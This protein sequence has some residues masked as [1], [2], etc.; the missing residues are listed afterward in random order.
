MSPDSDIDIDNVPDPAKAMYEA[1][2]FDEF[3]AHY[4]EVHASRSV[5]AAH[6]VATSLALLLLARAIA[7]RSL[8][9]AL[10]API[11][12]YAIAQSSHRLEGERTQPMWRPWW[13]LRAE[14]RLFRGTLRSVR[15]RRRGHRDRVLPVPGPPG[16]H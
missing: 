7:K 8:V 16:D 13:H 2:D 9:T 6:A 15:Q 10:A 4:Q 1:E 12:D 5:R 11:V 14:L 3:W